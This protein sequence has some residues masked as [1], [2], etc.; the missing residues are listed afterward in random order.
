MGNA[1]RI[2]TLVAATLA[3]AGAA[4]AHHSVAMFD[5]GRETII[6]GVL[7][8]MQ[9][10][11]PHS[12][13]IVTV[14]SADGSMTDW[15]LESGPPS[16]LAQM[17]FKRTDFKAGEHVTVRLHPMRDGQ[18]LGLFMSMVRADGRVVA[19]KGE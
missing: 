13:L 17:G 11:N 9:W 7:K 1:T 10:T 2:P 14:T 6:E 15:S 18:P 16:M 3:L 4:R 19:P 5:T 12:W 8:D